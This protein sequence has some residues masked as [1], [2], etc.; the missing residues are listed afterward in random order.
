MSRVRIEEEL[1]CSRPTAKRTIEAM[2]LY[3]EA[4]IEYDRERNGYF[5]ASE[6]KYELPGLWFKPEELLALNTVQQLLCQIQPG[7]LDEHIAPLR[8]RIDSMLK[9]KRLGGDEIGRRIRILGMAIR[10]TDPLH[11]NV[12]TAGLLQRKQIRITYHDRTRSEV[13]ERR[14]SPQRLVH[15]RD[16]WYLDAWCH[17]REALRTFALER[18]I[19]PKIERHVAKAM[20]DAELDRHFAASYGIFAGAATQQAVLRFSAQTAQWVATERWHPRQEG[21][22]LDDGQYQ[23]RI[24]Y[25]DPRELIMDILKYGPDVEVLAPP[26]LRAAVAARLV[27]AH[28]VYGK[29]IDRGLTD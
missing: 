29:E 28:R 3:L 9:S 5:Y 12:L 16:H 17:L 11:F 4:P 10:P 6:S 19:K 1:E 2:R 25:G 23:L 13:T 20:S 7:L 14:I 27:A 15:Y 21:Q 8:Q 24:P 22:L 18:I 26:E